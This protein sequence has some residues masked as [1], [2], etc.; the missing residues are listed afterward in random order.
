MS[1]LPPTAF[2]ATNLV[3]RLAVGILAGSSEKDGWCEWWV[4]GARNGTDEL[5]AGVEIEGEEVGLFD[6]WWW[7]SLT[8]RIWSKQFRVDHLPTCVPKKVDINSFLHL[9]RCKTCWGL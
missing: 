8:C 1:L 3:G 5:V 9:H 2:D 4:D 7:I 6:G